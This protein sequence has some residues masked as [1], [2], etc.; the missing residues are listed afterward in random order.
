MMLRRANTAFTSSYKKSL[1]QSEHAKFLKVE[2]GWGGRLDEAHD[3]EGITIR[4]GRIS[5]PDTSMSLPWNKAA[6][7]ITELIKLGCYLSEKEKA[8]YPAYLEQAEAAAREVL[9]RAPGTSS[10]LM[11]LHPAALSARKKVK[12]AIRTL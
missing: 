3:G 4:R 1:S 8:H 5:N 2:Y 6:K 7:R 10:F 12:P 11:G 9:G